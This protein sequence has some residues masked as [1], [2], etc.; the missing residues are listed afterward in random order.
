MHTKPTI[1]DLQAVATSD[2]CVTI[3]ID[4][5]LSLE[6]SKLLIKGPERLLIMSI[7][8]TSHVIEVCVYTGKPMF[9]E[10][11]TPSGNSVQYVKGSGGDFYNN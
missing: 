7:V 3:T 11:E 4:K 8:P 6:G 1:Q 2:E 5:D 9:V 10:L